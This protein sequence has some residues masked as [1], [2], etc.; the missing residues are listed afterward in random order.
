MKHDKQDIHQ[1]ERLIHQ[2]RPDI[3]QHKPVI[4]QD[5]PW[6]HEVLK[7]VL[8]PNQENHIIASEAQETCGREGRK[9]VRT[10]QYMEAL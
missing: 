6:L 3:H 7:I 4:F 10:R 2:Y 5:G 8:N 1:G 9:N